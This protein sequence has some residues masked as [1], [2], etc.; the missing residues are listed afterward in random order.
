MAK[1]WVDIDSAAVGS[2]LSSEPA[3]IA[4]LQSEADRVKAAAVAT[5]QDAQNG[6]GGTID[7]YAEAGFTSEVEVRSRRTRAVVRSN[8][9]GAIALAAHFNSQRKTG[10]AHLR[11]ALK[12]IT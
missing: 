11:A 9:D 3:L 12:T 1:A 2:L 6:P 10:V 7:G 8:A 5:A 4:L